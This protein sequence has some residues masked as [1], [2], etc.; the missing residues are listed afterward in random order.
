MAS[1]NVIFLM[2][3]LGQDPEL[4]RTKSDRAVATLNIATSRSWTDDKTGEV[5]EETEWHRVVVWGK[6]AEAVAAH[7]K[8]GDQIHV[9]GEMRYRKY[10]DD[11]G[12]ER[13]TAEVHAERVLFTGRAPSSRPNHPADAFEDQ[14]PPPSD[15]DI[16]F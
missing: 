13:W 2:G 5:H 14:P 8:K 15:D 11:K 7:K 6:Q 9:Q 16:P 4:R 3:N 12:I 10:T 1:V